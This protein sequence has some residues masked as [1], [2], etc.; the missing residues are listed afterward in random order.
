MTELYFRDWA[1]LKSCFGSEYVRTKIGPDGA[2]FNDL[3]T[4]IPLMVTEKPLQFSSAVDPAGLPE[5]GYRTVAVLFVAAM[6]GDSA[7]KLEQ[8]FSRALLAALGEYAKGDVYGVQA[9]VS[10]P[11][12]QFDIR[13]Y[14]GG[15]NMPEYPVTYKVFIKDESGVGAV[16]KAQKAFMEGL[17]EQIDAGNTF[18]GFGKEGLVL[19]AGNGVEVRSMWFLWWSLC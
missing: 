2:N 7:E 5:D 8:G 13:A 3:E 17:S 18:I 10:I 11:A 14:F 6:S 12:S 16:R 1:H 15:R 9:N 19:D 4:A